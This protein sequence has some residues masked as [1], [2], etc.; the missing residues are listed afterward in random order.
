MKFRFKERN[1]RMY[2]RR[3]RKEAG[4]DRVDVK[5]QK[6]EARRKGK[7]KQAWVTMLSLARYMAVRQAS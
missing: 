5:K 4:L 2:T 6:A 1:A 3:E 7:G